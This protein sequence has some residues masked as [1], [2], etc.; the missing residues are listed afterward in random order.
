M[1]LYFFSIEDGERI[2]PDGGYELPDD[3]A[4]RRHAERISRD[5]SKGREDGANWLITVTDEKG[6]EVAAVPTKWVEL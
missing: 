6:H 3:D 5:L 1:P 2:P 4:A